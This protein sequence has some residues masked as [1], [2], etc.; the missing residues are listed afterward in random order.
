M[1][2]LI[3]RNNYKESH[4]FSLFA[5]L[6]L[7]TIAIYNMITMISDHSSYAKLLNMSGKQRMLSQRVSLLATQ[8]KKEESIEIQKILIELKSNHEFLINRKLSKE[9]ENIY[10][11]KTHNLNK[12]LKQ[13]IELNYKYLENKNISD[14]KKIISVQNKIL[15]SLDTVVYTIENESKEFSDFMIKVEV[16]IILFIALL[17]YIESNYIFKPML[18]KIEKERQK[19]KITKEKLEELVSN[20]TK[21]LEESLEIINHYVFSSKTDLN[22]VITY[23]SDAFCELSGYSKEELIGKTHNVIKHPDNPSSAF[24]LLWKTLT[25]GKTYKGEVKNRKKNGEDFWLNSLIHPEFN[26]KSEIIGYIAY[27]KNITHEKTLENLNIKL[28]N[29]VEEKTKELKKSNARLLKLSQTD[30]LTG[31][32]N[33]KKLQESLS[34]E[35]KKAYRYNQVFSIILI[36]IDHFKKVNDIY[37]H[38]TGD[39][40]IK[41]ICNLISQNIRDIDLFARWGGEEFVILINNQNKHQAKQMA[42]KVRLEISRTKIDNLDI[43][44][45]F[46]ISQYE[47]GFDEKLIFQKADDALYKAKEEGRNKVIIG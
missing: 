43:T 19:E 12:T 13:F 41:G 45:S 24:S 3:N 42:E 33:R 30:A 17:L 47:K 31:I 21:S 36:D 25:S 6:F 39:N 18:K 27:R 20:K 11:Q 15:H 16:L 2:K 44:C 35:I 37:G 4:T 46:G 23:V 34:L 22:G 28:E 14:L 10:Y 5:I 8:Y 40:V 32:Y 9:L 7:I 1:I 26:E 29:M 38:L